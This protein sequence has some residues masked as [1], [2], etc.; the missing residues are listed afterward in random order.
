MHA[1]NADP[2]SAERV[3][4]LKRPLHTLKGGARMAGV[5]AMGDL[6]HELETLIAQI[7]SGTT[8]GDE[9]ARAVV[10]TTIDELARM[11]E[12]V[13]AGRPV[14]P[15]RELIARIHAVAQGAPLPEPVMPP[16]LMPPA[17]ALPYAMPP[18]PEPLA[19]AAQ[20]PHLEEMEFEVDLEAEGFAVPGPAPEPV[21]V[22]LP[23]AVETLPPE[24]LPAAPVV[25]PG[26]VPPGREPVVQPE[27]AEMA[28]VDAELLNQ[29]LNQ[30]GEVSIARARVEQQLG[31]VEFNLARAVAHRDA[32]EGA[33]AQARDR[34]RDADPASARERVR[35]AHRVRSARARPLF[36]ASSSSRAR[37][38]KPPAT[39]PA[40]RQLLESLTPRN[41]EPAAAAGSRTITE[42][43]NGLMRTRM[44]SF[45]RHV[46]RLSRIVRQAAA[47][48]GK[49]AELVVEGA[50]GELDR[51]V[52]ERMLPPFE[53]LLR[54]AVVHGIETPEQRL[55]RRQVR[56]RPDPPGAAPRGRR[57]HR[58]GQR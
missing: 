30:A 13:A 42:L 37:W 25:P 1:W 2:G 38:P 19:P 55:R 47:D 34:D 50:T 11:R 21:V 51:Q 48:T 14:A 28:R 18:P 49:Q 10:Q 35:P 40:S 6:A 31:S 43:Q 46:Q 17:A 16:P 54:N 20:V 5:R 3:A 24:P 8:A 58:R 22:T 45:Q 39:W 9:R 27:R 36:L 15:A 7:S 56:G 44:V 33:A 41:A 12:L 23:P 53:H 4:A 52:L 32:P 57:G 26:L 29:L